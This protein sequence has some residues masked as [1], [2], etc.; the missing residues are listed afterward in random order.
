MP[1]LY[2]R[3]CWLGLEVHHLLPQIDVISKSQV[4]YGLSI[5]GN[6]CA[7]VMECFLH[8]LLQEQVEQDV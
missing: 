5:H 3:V 2:L 7:V 1:L 6:V 8:D 4:A